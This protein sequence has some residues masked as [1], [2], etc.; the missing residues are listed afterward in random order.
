MVLCYGKLSQLRHCPVTYLLTNLKFSEDVQ[1]QAVF[2]KLHLMH[3]GSVHL[4]GLTEILNVKSIRLLSRQRKIF[5]RNFAII[6]ISSQIT[7][8]IIDLSE[9]ALKPWWN[10]LE[11]HGQPTQFINPM[12]FDKKEENC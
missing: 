5:Y 10:L 8:A 4:N 6:Y 11:S 3:E 7:V 9:G 1:S 12:Y 2:F